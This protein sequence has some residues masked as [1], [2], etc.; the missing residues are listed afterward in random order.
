MG[1]QIGVDVAVAVRPGEKAADRGV[2]ARPAGGAQTRARGEE[3][4][5]RRDV[6]LTDVAAVKRG[7]ARELGA[8]RAQGVRGAAGVLELGE[9]GAGELRDG[10]VPRLV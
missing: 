6:E 5:Q 4:A 7:E 10:Q 2:G 1:H 9:V 8:V 3:R